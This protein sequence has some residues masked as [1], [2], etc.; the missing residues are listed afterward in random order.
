MVL[1]SPTA[2]LGGVRGLLNRPAA[3]MLVLS[4]V[5]FAVL[6][7]VLIPWD[8]VPGGGSIRHVP[9]D[10]VFTAAEIDR[11]ETYSSLVRRTR[12]R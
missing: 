12:S 8:W 11:A 4:S 5:L 10:Q 9:A 7:A 1:L 2:S 6:A 3:V